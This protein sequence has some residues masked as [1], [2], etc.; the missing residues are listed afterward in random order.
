MTFLGKAMILIP[1]PH[2]AGNHQYIN[3]KSIEKNAALSAALVA[4]SQASQ[5]DTSYC[6]GEQQ[7]IEWQKICA[8]M[9]L[10]AMEVNHAI[11]KKD[12]AAAKLGLDRIVK[13][14]DACHHTFRD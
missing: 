5:L 8:D 12:Q 10:A 6:D 9:G 4:M 2:S 7:E 14:C 11:R 13:T 3:A 1:L